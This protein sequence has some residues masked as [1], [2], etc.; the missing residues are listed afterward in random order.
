MITIGVEI[1]GEKIE[2]R[3]DD[4]RLL[5]PVDLS[6]KA[7]GAEVKSVDGLEHPALCQGDLCIPL[8]VAGRIDV[9]EVDG[10][11]FIYADVFEE[12][13]GYRVETR[14][15]GV[16]LAKDTNTSGIGP[17]DTPP[18]FSLPDMR[19]GNSVSVTDFVGQKVVFYMWASW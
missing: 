1:E 17:G 18:N 16:V 15:D 2:G 6:A 13:M 10:V 12:P 9:R 4:G 7:I 11:S 5:L 3:M 8:N 14:E 19:S